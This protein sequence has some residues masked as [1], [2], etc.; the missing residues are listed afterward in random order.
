[1]LL[2]P[3]CP[4]FGPILVLVALLAGPWVSAAAAQADSAT[5]IAGPEYAAGDLHEAL[6]GDDYRD[7]WT[8][9]VRVPVLD[10][11]TFAGGLTSVRRGGGMQTVSLRFEAP[12]GREFNFRSV[13]KEITKGLPPWLQETWVDYLLQDQTSSIHPAAA[14]IASV[15][16]DSV[17]VLNPGPRLVVLP[18]D[19]R[20][21]RFR[22]EFAGRL[23]W[24]ET[25]AD[26]NREN[27]ELGFADAIR[28]AGTDRV[29]EHLEE[30]PDDR[31][32]SRAYLKAR[33]MDI[34]FGDWDRHQGQFRWARYDRGGIQWW[35]PIPEDRD[36]VFPNYDGALI[37]LGQTLFIPRAIPFRSEYRDDLLPLTISA[38]ELDRRLLSDLPREVYDSMAVWLQERLTDE[39]IEAALRD[40]PPEWYEESADDLRSALR[41][42]RDRFREVAEQFYEQLAIAPEVHATDEPDLAQVQRL[43]GGE[44]RVRLSLRDPED[45]LAGPYFER[46]FQPEATEEIRI[47]LHGDDDL[48]I[49]RGDVDESILVRVIGGGSD[50]VLVDSS[51]VRGARVATA[52]Y[53]DQ[54]ENEFITGPN[55]VVD[56]SQYEAPE[57]ERTVFSLPPRD[58]GHSFSWFSPAVGYRGAV[59]GVIVGGGPTFTQYGFRQRPYAYRL[60]LRGLIAPASGRLG[61]RARGDFRR[62]GSGESLSVGASAT[63]LEAIRFY[64]FGNETLVGGDDDRFV[65]PL[66]QFELEAAYHFPLADSVGLAVGPVLKYTDPEVD[67]G[68]PIARLRPYGSE[69]FGQ[70][71]AQVTLRVDTRDRPSFPRSGARIEV[72]ADAYPAAWDAEEAFGSV[73][74]EASTYAALPIGMRPVV[75]LRAGG[76]NVLGR[77]PLHEAAFLGGSRTVRGYPYQRFAGDALLYGN[78]A[79]RVPIT[80]ANLIVRG[81]LGASVFADAGRVYFDGESPGG[82]HTAVGGGVW[83]A[84][85][86]PVVSVSYAQGEVGRLYLG[87]GM[88][89]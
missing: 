5:V 13:N 36:Y 82:W 43:P 75:A 54:G 4:R 84:T 39:V 33:L 66:E 14:G 57:P 25:H 71:G 17:G 69:P 89:F 34:F 50:D 79:L 61:V 24:I 3:V 73:R 32:A 68:T 74:A 6:L 51:R 83:F 86:G 67:A 40:M 27:P 44:V 16:L 85:P 1:M 23:G 88:P 26:E 45:E 28:V 80:E 62:A 49:V 53:D 87:L 29:L 21:G 72:G 76:Q 64:G 65:V 81:D 70:L 20:L 41:G 8:A 9:P 63:Q 7:V 2:K 48:A 55:T 47:D 37:W 58:W 46:T 12:A 31:V 38:Q 19:P 52:F 10:L 35:V 77:F 42:R 11:D 30:S 22:E 15:L 56:T 18:D 78:A 60:A 59:G